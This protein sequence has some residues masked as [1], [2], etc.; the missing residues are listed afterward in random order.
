MKI[1]IEATGA[2]RGFGVVLAGAKE[3]LK[4]NSGL[5]IMLVGG[6]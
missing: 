1:A 5:G 2:D 3:Y 6:I 4:T